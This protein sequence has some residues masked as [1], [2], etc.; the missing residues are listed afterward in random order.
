MK[1]LH[2]AALLAVTAFAAVGSDVVSGWEGS[3][4]L[5]AVAPRI[6]VEAVPEL[7]VDAVRATAVADGE[8]QGIG[9]VIPVE[10]Q[11][12]LD[13][14][15]RICF[16]ASWRMTPYYGS[17]C[18]FTLILDNQVRINTLVDIPEHGWARI[19]VPVSRGALSLPDGVS[20]DDVAGCKVTQLLWWPNNNLDVA[21]ESIAIAALEL[22]PRADSVRPLVPVSVHVSPKPERNPD[23]AGLTDGRIDAASQMV[24]PM[25]GG[26][27][28]ML[29]D[30]GT[31][32]LVEAIAVTTA[33]GTPANIQSVE[34]AF[35]NEDGK[36][37]TAG[38]LETMDAAR[39][40][41]AGSVSGI[42]RF[43]RLTLRRPRHD[44]PAAVAEVT[45][46]GRI[47]GLADY[48]NA[49]SGVYDPGLELPPL[50]PQS[51][52]S[53]ENAH[54]AFALH[55]GNGILCGVYR[56]AE[57]AIARLMPLFKV[58][59]ADGNVIELEPYTNRVEAIRET[60]DGVEVDCS[61]PAYSAL[62]FTR[63]YRLDG[64]G[65]RIETVIRRPDN[66]DRVFIQS[67]TRVV[68]PEEL[69]RDGVYETAS[70]YHFMNRKFARD[71]DTAIAVDNY[72]VLFFE[73]AARNLSFLSF[74]LGRNGEFV[75]LDTEADSAGKATRFTANGWEWMDTV[76]DC[77]RPENRLESRVLI[78]D[79]S[80][81]DA[82]RLYRALPEF[83]QYYGWVRRP[84]WFRQA[85]CDVGAGRTTEH[86][87][88]DYSNFLREGILLRSASTEANFSWGDLP[89]AGSVRGDSGMV[90]SA[91]ELEAHYRELRERY[92]RLK[93][94][95]YTWL[96]SVIA[97]SD[98]YRA[99]PEMTIDRDRAGNRIS[100]WPVGR[101]N[102]YRNL[103]APG[104]LELT[105]R[106]VL[107][108]LARYR[109][110]IWY[111]DGGSAMTYRN[112]QTMEVSDPL[113]WHKLY[114]GVRRILQQQENAPIL[115]FN[116]PYQ[117]FC[118][119]GLLENSGDIF[120]NWR[121]AAA[122]F[123]KIKL[124]QVDDPYHAPAY[125]YW[126]KQ[127]DELY[128]A[129]LAVL[130][131][132]PVM[133]H[134]ALTPAEVP[135]LTAQYEARLSELRDGVV[136]PDWRHDPE[137]TLES[138]AVVDG[139]SA[140]VLLRS[141]AEETKTY[142]VRFDFSRFGFDP[143]RPLYALTGKLQRY[144][145][146]DTAGRLA[147]EERAAIYCDTG[148][149]E[150]RIFAF[151]VLTD[152]VPAQAQWEFEASTAYDY[153]VTA[154]A[155]LLFSIDGLPL[156]MPRSRTLEQQ[157][158]GVLHGD[159]IALTLDLTRHAEIAAILPE[160]MAVAA[161]EIDGEAV[162][163]RYLAISG[164]LLAIVPAAPGA[165]Q[166][167]LQLAPV[168]GSGKT[169][170]L[171]PVVNDGGIDL[172]QIAP[173]DVTV[174]V[175]R[176]GML[177][178][179]GDFAAGEAMRIPL[180]H[181]LQGGSYEVAVFDRAGREAGRNTVTLA[182]GTPR[183]GMTPVF[184]RPRLHDS[185]TA[186]VPGDGFAVEG[187][188]SSISEG[189]LTAAFQPEEAS[190]ELATVPVLPGDFN[191]GAALMRLSGKRFW[192]I[193]L[194]GNFAFFNTRG[195]SV[196]HSMHPAEAW[197]A[198][199]LVFDFHTPAGDT[200]RS[201]GSIGKLDPR[202]RI[203]HKLHGVVKQPDHWFMLSNFVYESASTQRFWIDSRSLGAPADWDGK[204]AVGAILD[205]VAADRR[206]RVKVLRSA[207][208][209][210]AGSTALAPLDMQ[211]ALA[212]VRRFPVP[213]MTEEPLLDG[214]AG[215]GAYRQLRLDGFS[216]L[217]QPG[218][219]SS[220]PTAVS[221]ARDE[222][223]LYIHIYAGESERAID[224]Q[225]ETDGAALFGTDS[226]EFALENKRD[227]ETA[228]HVLL[229]PNNRIYCKFDALND[230]RE[231][232]DAPL[233]RRAVAV[234]P[235]VAYAAEFAVPLEALGISGTGAGETLGFNV[236]RNRY[237]D[238]GSEH[239]TLVPGGKYLNLSHYQ[240]EL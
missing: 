56:G 193:E 32:T 207:D 237:S 98:F 144:G 143:A 218:S 167:S 236:M 234:E 153:Q 239:L 9:W 91:D 220:Q 29:F 188:E 108:F 71:V 60:A 135:Y 168:L 76:L 30:L 40:S 238:S 62:R 7:G 180:H 128:P 134:K 61:N 176:Q 69:R 54:G 231:A 136:S 165:R 140:F 112:W 147:E 57:V 109:Q 230:Y 6:S 166:G 221:L 154:S 127:A 224:T 107:D 131:T 114:A 90:Q 73:N 44:V 155:A 22:Y 159:T 72:P 39:N 79:G 64:D 104:C 12:E 2:L 182:A 120:T 205:H 63:A 177:L 222:R 101:V 3:V 164:R 78:C 228:Y 93:I 81:L 129:Y 202:Y 74:F 178:Y 53:Y 47:P 213:V 163:W 37:R 160:G 94:G 139:L 162:P 145:V 174:Q 211:A 18:V 103:E 43:L 83:Q 97:D 20:Y 190:F 34:V 110:D 26:D 229:G 191:F 206:L 185:A 88:E 49:P 192:E 217:N 169:V 117:V 156:Q 115:F 198:M 65:L 15:E 216:K 125:I 48:R 203:E 58:E 223:N 24:F 14:L 84:A 100:I 210:P 27:P 181:A 4:G 219:A 67:G 116:A 161:A 16:A 137:T 233:P 214:K 82:Y 123:Y 8:Y 86:V 183:I 89:V 170:A 99:H 158:D 80:I 196:A 175:Y 106:H 149:M 119:V 186:A 199:T 13:R 200:V 122:W 141:H 151:E 55:R 227:P 42:G 41:I 92:P 118:D 1:R 23:P 33:P 85:R 179:A 195:I 187:F 194:S 28:E 152:R 189:G 130:G 173:E 17:A 124:F 102:P 38:T 45:L 235:G 87:Y 208:T 19:E 96:W 142:P 52:V 215:E 36:F 21:G 5:A 232:Q 51:Y 148:W 66:G 35:G 95:L 126:W 121:T 171:Q 46:A 209:L 204:V 184:P 70:V 77:R 11:P 133:F 50:S 68:L 25:F 10:Q 157:A 226:I 31:E 225:S 105:Q 172:R 132:F 240:L 201:L 59:F 75:P 113:Y 146:A 212:G 138:F 111:L 197:H 150:D